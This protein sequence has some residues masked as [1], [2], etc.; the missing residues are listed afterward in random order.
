[1]KLK[2]LAYKYFTLS[3]ALL[4]K[5]RIINFFKMIFAYLLKIIY[6]QGLPFIIQI[7]PTNRC[8]LKCALCITG[9]G[10]LRRAAG[11]MTFEEFEKIIKKIDKNVF[12]LGLYNLGEPLLNPEIH[13]MISFAKTKRI[14]TRLSTNAFFDSKEDIAKLVNSGIDELV[15]SL[16]CVTPQIYAKYK[17]ADGF[18]RVIRNIRLIIK[19]RANKLS[20]FIA[21]QLLVMKETEKEIK[22][23]K[24]L[25]YELG[26]DKTVLK[27]IRINFPGAIGDKSFLPDNRK[28]IRKT[29]IKRN[30]LNSSC[31]RSW[32]STVILWDG[33][34]VPCCFDMEGEYNFGNIHNQSLEEIW[35]NEK[36]VSFRKEASDANNQ[37]NLCKECSLND[38]SQSINLF[39]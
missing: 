6:S 30:N 27:K 33:C 31:F 2:I 29:Y 14:F 20:P 12:Y 4:Y 9:A 34:I 28:Y 39:L 7:E 15:V 24:K 17:G 11:D 32:I 37:I 16:D 21:L 36:Y 22:T 8:N 38:L 18:Q 25:A 35:R 26:V 19:E 3:I 13:K 23:F 5:F 10:K 1:M